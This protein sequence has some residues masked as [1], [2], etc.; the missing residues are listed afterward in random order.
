MKPTHWSVTD[1]P[2]DWHDDPATDPIAAARDFITGESAM[3]DAWYQRILPSIVSATLTLLADAPR[4]A[5]NAKDDRAAAS[6]A[7]SPSPC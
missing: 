1:N 4:Q 5:S 2:E 7:P 6:A 3:D